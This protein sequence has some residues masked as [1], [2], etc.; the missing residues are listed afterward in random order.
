MNFLNPLC[1]CLN[2]IHHGM[3]NTREKHIFFGRTSYMSEIFTYRLETG[4][5]Y[6]ET[7]N[8]TREAFW[9]VYKPGCD[10][11]LLLHNLRKAPCYID[12]LAFLCVKA[13]GRIIGAS[14]SSKGEI[15]DTEVLH[16]AVIIGP[17]AVHPEFQKQGIGLH[18][19]ELTLNR[20]RELG[21][22]CALL[23]GNPDYYHKSGF[24]EAKEFDIHLA[25]GSDMSAF[26]CCPLDSSRMPMI[27]GRYHDD[28][29][30]TID[31]IK[32]AEFDK[33]FPVKEKH[34]RPGQIFG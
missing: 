26:M 10:E 1:S 32:V 11:H 13:D 7:E 34:K 22:S 33:H 12:D 23:Y 20:A 24:T 3:S 4:H 6:A 19:L 18:L 15:K 2:G 27:K 28:P 21:F 14:Y 25:D 9:N 30:F 29:V 5:D 31:P 17:I 16:E 8:L